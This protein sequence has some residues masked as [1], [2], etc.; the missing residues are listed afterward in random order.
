MLDFAVFGFC[1]A[2]QLCLQCRWQQGQPVSA[3]NHTGSK[4]ATAELIAAPSSL[5]GFKSHLA[6]EF[7]LLGR[8]GDWDPATQKG[9]PMH[10]MQ[11]SN[12]LKGYANHA[13]EL[14]CEKKGALPFAKNKMH[15]LLSSMQQMLSHTTDAAQQPLTVRKGLQSSILWQTC[16]RGFNAGGVRLENNALP[17]GGG[18]LPYL[19]PNKLPCGA[20][21]HML[22]APTKTRGPL[23]CHLD[24]QS[25]VLLHM[26]P[27]SCDSLC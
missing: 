18:A 6:A 27:A 20:V 19:M 10:S 24:M 12:M 3:S 14:G 16:Y 21:L 5:S 13:T 22:P 25:A 17:T 2:N 4:T 8:I 9:N 11:V 7:E 15:M 1:M 23:H 26:A